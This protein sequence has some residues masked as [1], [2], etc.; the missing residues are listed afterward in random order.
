MIEVEPDVVLVIYPES[1]GEIRPSFVRAQH[2][3]ITPGGPVRG[4]GDY[5]G[6]GR[7]KRWNTNSVLVWLKHDQLRS[8]LAAGSTVL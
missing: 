4:R 5:S 1:M 3:R 6:A 7:E 8:P 2:L